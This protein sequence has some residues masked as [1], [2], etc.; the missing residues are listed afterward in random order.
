MQ[1]IQNACA[2]NELRPGEQI[3]RAA[4]RDEGIFQP[5]GQTSNYRK[6]PI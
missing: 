4:R 5:D 6:W 3:S 2:Q 1:K